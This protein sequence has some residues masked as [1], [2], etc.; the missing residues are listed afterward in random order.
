M[1]QQ[2]PPRVTSTVWKSYLHVLLALQCG[3][4]LLC[5]LVSKRLC[6]TSASIMGQETDQ[7]WVWWSILHHTFDASTQE[8]E[9]G[10]FESEVNLVYIMS[11]RIARKTP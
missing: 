6:Q 10:V 1:P 2:M 4:A 11:S 7:S 9:V 8:A 5:T 3:P